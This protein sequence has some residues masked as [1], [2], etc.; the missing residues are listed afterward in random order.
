M[1]KIRR[2]AEMWVIRGT[3]RGEDVTIVVEAASRAEAECIGL[4]KGI[5]AV[6]I[7]LATRSEIA[8]ARANKL[9]WRC[10]REPRLTVFGRPVTHNQAGMLV[11]LGWAVVLLNLHANHVPLSLVPGWLTGGG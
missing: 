2:N 4:K 10:S 6:I 11:I 8:T 3:L 5:D 1:N 9:L 7:D